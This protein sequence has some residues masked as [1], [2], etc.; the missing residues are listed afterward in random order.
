M[1]GLGGFVIDEVQTRGVLFGRQ[2]QPVSFAGTPES[3]DESAGSGLE[4]TLQRGLTTNQ[5]DLVDEEG[6]LSLR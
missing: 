3:D 1:A 5:L 4:E 6:N 2:Q